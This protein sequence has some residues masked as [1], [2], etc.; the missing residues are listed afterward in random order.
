VY[1]H[2]HGNPGP[3]LYTPHGW[4]LNR[5]QWHAS[6]VTLPNE[7]DAETLT[8]LV[9]EGL[10]RVRE[11]FFCCPKECTRFEAERLVQLGYNAAGEAILFFP[12][13]T[14]KGLAFPDQGSA[15]DQSRLSAL[16]RLVVAESSV[17]PVPAPGGLVH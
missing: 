3:G 9:A 17:S 10:Y 15:V 13:W 1:F 12:E 2:N 14:P 4:V 11:P 8:P 7:R 5:A 16:D 6:G